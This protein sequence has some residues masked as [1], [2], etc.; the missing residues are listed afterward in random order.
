M[1]GTRIALLKEG[2]L[3]IVASVDEF[4]RSQSQEAQAFLATLAEG[5]HAVQ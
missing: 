1:L 2:R 5:P 4:P 3:E